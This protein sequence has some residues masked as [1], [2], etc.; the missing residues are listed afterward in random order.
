V[1][2]VPE[3]KVNHDSRSSVLLQMKRLCADD[4]STE[5][6]MKRAN[7]FNAAVKG[8]SQQI[9]VIASLI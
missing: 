5:S 7:W 8:F 4:D 6:K 1:K 3:I 2:Q 9:R